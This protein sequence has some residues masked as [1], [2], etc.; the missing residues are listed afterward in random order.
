MS[1]GPPSGYRTETAELPR[2]CG[3]VLAV[4][5]GNLGDP[6]RH[7]GKLDWFYLRRPF[8][9]PLLQLLRH[10]GVAIGSCGVAPRRM[11]LH[12]RAIRAGLLADM[13]VDARHRTL[14]PALMLQESLLAAA[15]GRFDFVYGFPNRKSLPVVR[16][17]G[18]AVLGEMPRHSR[19]L[20]HASYL[21]RRLP[22]WLAWP[23]GGLLD[24]AFALRDRLRMAAAPRVLATWSDQVDPRM[25]ALWQAAPQRQGLLGVRDASM[26]RWRF[27]EMPLSHTRF[28]LLSDGA[29]GPLRAWFAC[30]VAGGMLRVCDYWCASATVGIDAALVLGLVR[31]ARAAGHASIS[32]EHAAGAE[33]LAGWRRAGFVHRDSR[34]VVGKWLGDG[35][36]PAGLARDWYLTAADEDE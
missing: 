17:L 14:G 9:P 26:V 18:Y 23:L 34:P 27:D 11:L 19:V 1:D 31:A 8:G 7:A 13:A 20:R 12:G 2:D 36:A 4:W 28:L 29:D 32:L 24:A 30:Q 16:R 35:P 25:E 15:A 5:D 21:Q 33:R 22:H 3:A 10:D 6:A